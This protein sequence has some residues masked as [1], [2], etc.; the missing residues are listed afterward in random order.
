MN[1]L[2]LL[3]L[4]HNFLK[5]RSSGRAYE[6][7]RR[8]KNIK[9]P[10]GAELGV[11]NGNLSVLLL[12]NKTDL[13]LHMIDSWEGE[14]AGYIGDTEDSVA[15]FSH[16]YMNDIFAKTMQRTDFAK[17]R[18]HVHRMRTDKAHAALADGSLDF[19]FIDAD[20]SYEGCKSDIEL[21]RPKIKAGGWLG[22]HDYDHPK[23]PL[24][25]VKRAVDE[26]AQAHHHRLETGKNYTWF[27]PL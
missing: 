13:T 3:F 26:Y 9:N 5:P 19:C 25:G 22:G 17:D 21:Y 4:K 6:V 14:G 20:H 27:I 8:I 1:C 10:V 24:F 18:R 11:F 12:S 23:Y 2:Q 7:L 15:T 16:Q